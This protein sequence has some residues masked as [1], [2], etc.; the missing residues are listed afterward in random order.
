MHWTWFRIAAAVIALSGVV[1][2]FIVNVDRA[3]GAA[4]SRAGPRQLL[5]PLHD[6]LDDRSASSRSWRPRSG[7]M[8][9]PGSTREPLRDRTRARGRGR[10][11]CS[12][13]GIVY[14]V[15]LR[16]DPSERRARG[17][18]GDR[19]AGLLGDRDAARRRC[20]STSLVD[21]LLAPRR[22]G[23][24]WWSLAVLVAYPDRCGSS[25]RWCAASAWPTPTAAT[26]WW[27]PYPFLDPHDAAAA[28]RRFAYIGVI[29]V[30]LVAIG[31][32]DHRDRP[33]PREASVPSAAARLATGAVHA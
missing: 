13:L 1:A 20:R 4:G 15:L 28:A 27:Y 19:T 31:A 29:T 3:T 10:P 11:A 26:T 8:R 22:R 30:A 7:R 9:H 24:P 6:R 5:Q 32:V 17:L 2:G 33:L 14:N 16:D 25:T 23:L 12:L 21:L 18:C